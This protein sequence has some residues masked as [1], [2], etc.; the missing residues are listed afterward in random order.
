MNFPNVPK[1]VK[2][3]AAS[4]AV[5]LTRT[6]AKRSKKEKLVAL[7]AAA[8]IVTTWASTKMI[9]PNEFGLQQTMGVVTSDV[10]GPGLYFQVPFAQITHSYRSN[11]Q[12]LQFGAGSNRF[13]PWKIDTSDRNLL[14]ADVAVNYKVIPDAQKLAFWRWAMRDWFTGRNGYWLLTDMANTSANVVLGQKTMAETLSK[15]TEFAQD[16]YQDLSTRL[17]I[18]NIPVQI[19][20]IEVNGVRTTFWPTRSVQ[21]RKVVAQD[22]TANP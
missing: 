13:F 19:Q 3:F 8:L 18:N 17:D 7:A 4:A 2:L 14:V 15:P 16:Y 21:Y 12:T 20:S 22:S 1:L 9:G 6:L 5:L 11:T 10:R